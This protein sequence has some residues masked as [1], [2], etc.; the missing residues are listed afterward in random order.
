LGGGRIEVGPAEG[1]ERKDGP[2]LKKKRGERPSSETREEKR[3]SS[4]EW[5]RGGRDLFHRRKKRGGS[6]FFFTLGVGKDRVRSFMEEERESGEFTFERRI[7]G[8][9]SNTRKK[10]TLHFVVEKDREGKEE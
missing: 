7:K 2:L 9:F 1:K 8:T 3:I 10:V 5:Y 6:I 4:D